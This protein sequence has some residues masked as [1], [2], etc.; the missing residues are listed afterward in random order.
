MV[1]PW[2]FAETSQWLSPF[3]FRPLGCFSK[4]RSVLYLLNKERA[5]F[6]NW[7]KLWHKR[8]FPTKPS[9]NMVKRLWDDAWRHIVSST[10]MVVSWPR[11]RTST[12]RTSDL[13]HKSP[14][15]S[16][17]FPMSG[18]KSRSTSGSRLWDCECGFKKEKDLSP[19]PPLMKLAGLKI[20][21]KVLTELDKGL[22][23]LQVCQEEMPEQAKLV[24]RLQRPSRFLGGANVVFLK[25]GR[26]WR[27]CL[28]WN[29]T[30][31]RD[32][33]S[34]QKGPSSNLYK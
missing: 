21:N 33:P 9:Q 26:S 24:S 11:E 7:F 12:I 27:L 23:L 19:S 1:L 6:Q 20:S 10:Q 22:D 13:P 4:S 18:G 28:F 30:Y 2:S 8:R 32:G 14:Y 15:S 5:T 31:T 29:P 17:F 25:L 34:R 16:P 3:T